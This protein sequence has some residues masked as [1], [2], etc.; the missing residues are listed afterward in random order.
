LLGVA[1]P[2]SV[3]AP[4]DDRAVAVVTALTG[5]GHTADEAGRVDEALVAIRRRVELLRR[6][7]SA[8]DLAAALMDLA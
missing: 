2:E 4:P 5:L 3:H 7:G 8:F 6:H 1:F